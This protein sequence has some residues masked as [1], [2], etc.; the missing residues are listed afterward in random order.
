VLKLAGFFGL[1]LCIVLFIIGVLRFTLPGIVAMA[2]CV[3][4]FLVA[5]YFFFFRKL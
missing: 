1:F 4:V 3:G 2:L 5:G